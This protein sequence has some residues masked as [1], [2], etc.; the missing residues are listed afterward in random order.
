MFL[1]LAVFFTLVF[2]SDLLREKQV[3]LL[4]WLEG[5]AYSGPIAI[6]IVTS[7]LSFFLMPV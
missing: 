3:E 1:Y 4:I 7:F 2:K 5:N 6:M